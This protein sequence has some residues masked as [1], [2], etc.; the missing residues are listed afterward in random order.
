MLQGIAMSNVLRN[1]FCPDSRSLFRYVGDPVNPPPRPAQQVDELGLPHD[2][3]QSV[4]GMP[5]EMILCLAAT[6]DLAVDE[7]SLSRE[8]VQRRVNLIEN[9]IKTWQPPALAAQALTENAILAM[10]NLVTGEMWRQV[11]LELRDQTENTLGLTVSL[12]FFQASL[13]FLYQAVLHLGPLAPRIRH[14]LAQLI[15]LG[16]RVTPP[17]LPPQSPPTSPLPTACPAT[18]RV[19]CWAIAATA[20]INEDDRTLCREGIRR[21]VTDR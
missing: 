17:L 18:E 20:C 12:P 21:A 6:S 1:V 3:A 16:S 2:F 11:R 5:I 9:K 15:A 10:E 13:I 4:W 8:E 14:A 19:C 7:P